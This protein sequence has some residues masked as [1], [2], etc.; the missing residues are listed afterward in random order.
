M[1]DLRER[2]ANLERLVPAAG[3]FV[4]IGVVSLAENWQQGEEISFGAM[5]TIGAIAVL[6]AIFSNEETRSEMYCEDDME[7][8]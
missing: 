8:F 7:E 4:F 1:H 6:R 5:I 3:I 2:I